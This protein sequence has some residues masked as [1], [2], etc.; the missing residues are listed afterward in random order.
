MK[1]HQVDKGHDRQR[2]AQKDSRVDDQ[3]GKRSRYGARSKSL[4][5]LVPN[6]PELENGVTVLSSGFVLEFAIHIEPTSL[7]LG[8]EAMPNNHRSGRWFVN[9]VPFESGHNQFL[10]TTTERRDVFNVN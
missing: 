5:G 3:C 2:M 6:S 10:A 9:T 8:W 7:H 1:R 4:W